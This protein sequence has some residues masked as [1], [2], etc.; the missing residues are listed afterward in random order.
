MSVSGI[1]PVADKEGAL[2]RLLAMK[3]DRTPTTRRRAA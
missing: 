1:C 2:V 3:R